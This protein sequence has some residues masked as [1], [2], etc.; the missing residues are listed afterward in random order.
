MFQAFNEANKDLAKLTPFERAIFKTLPPSELRYFRNSDLISDTDFMEFIGERILTTG[1]RE[2]DRAIQLDNADE[3]LELFLQMY[4]QYTGPAMPVATIHGLYVSIMVNYALAHK[5][6][7]TVRALINHEFIRRCLTKM[8]STKAYISPKSMEKIFKHID[9]SSRLF[10]ELFI[11]DSFI[12]DCIKVVPSNVPLLIESLVISTIESRHY[13]GIEVLRSI[14]PDTVNHTLAHIT[15]SIRAKPEQR[16]IKICLCGYRL[17][18]FMKRIDRMTVDLDIEN[19]VSQIYPLNKYVDDETRIYLENAYT[20]GIMDEAL[21]LLVN[22]GDFAKPIR[23][24]ICDYMQWKIPFRA[25]DMMTDIS[26]LLSTT[27]EELI[28]II[29]NDNPRDLLDAISDNTSDETIFIVLSIILNCKANKCLNS[30][31]IHPEIGP[32]V[33]RLM[34]HPINMCY[35]GHNRFYGAIAELGDDYMEPLEEFKLLGLMSATAETSLFARL[36]T[37]NDQI[38]TI[39]MYQF[40]DF[41]YAMVIGSIVHM[42]LDA[43]NW[44]IDELYGNEDEFISDFY[45][46]QSRLCDEFCYGEHRMIKV[47]NAFKLYQKTLDT[48]F[49]RDL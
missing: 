31:M 4:I 33:S 20:Y 29:E 11:E 26:R 21:A 37:I 46:R 9:T 42:N 28:A 23:E 43:Y 30:L 7:N 27:T 48:I 32:I 10:K 49:E 38:K 17:Y 41:R 19:R 8:L 15:D 18:C 40:D 12:M 24:T 5:A 14:D 1:L 22:K 34:T 13:D 35:S 6:D 3:S 36:F 25:C 47:F 45:L 44:L 2:I 16:F 39:P